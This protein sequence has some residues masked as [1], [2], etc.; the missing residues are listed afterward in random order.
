MEEKDIM[1]FISSHS[2]AIDGFSGNTF[3][4][5]ILPDP[6]MGKEFIDKVKGQFKEVEAW[7]ASN[8]DKFKLAARGYYKK[9]NKESSEDKKFDWNE[10]DTTEPPIEVDNIVMVVPGFRDI[11]GDEW[12]FLEKEPFMVMEMR[13][14]EIHVQ[15]W[16]KI[17]PVEGGSDV[18]EHLYEIF[19]KKAFRVHISLHPEGS[20][21]NN[22]EE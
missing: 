5:P 4:F 12:G 9:P 2:R 8:P 18:K 22:K 13:G 7:I 17:M 14:E 19:P 16:N 15:S 10:M 1:Y 20:K 11:L 3:E 21:S 6:E